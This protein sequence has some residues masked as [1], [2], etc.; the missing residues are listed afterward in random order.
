MEIDDDQLSARDVKA[1]DDIDWKNDEA[2]RGKEDHRTSKI[3]HDPEDK[4]M[5]SEMKRDQSD[6]DLEEVQD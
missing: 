2:Y 4:Q 6:Q 3:S 5:H 1:A